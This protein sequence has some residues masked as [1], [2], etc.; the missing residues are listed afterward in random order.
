MDKIARWCFK[1]KYIV[2]GLWIIALV[3]ISV[4]TKQFG[5]KYADSF[6]LPNSGS[7][8]A[9]NLLSKVSTS[10]SGEVDTV[11][12]RVK[13]GTVYDKE[14]K[15]QINSLIHKIS[16]TTQVASV[17]SPY[18]AIGST[19]IS[20]NG[21]IAYSQVN[22]YAQF[23]KLNKQNVLNV[24]ADVKNASNSKV[25][26]E[27]G[28]QAIEQSQQASTSNSEGIG[29][30]AAAIVLLVAFG[31]VYAMSVPLITALMALGVGIGS[32]GLA[33]HFLSIST[34][35][36]IIGALIG[37]GVGIDYAL[38]IITRYRSG[39]I[40]G[41]SPEE[42]AV[43]AIN[44]AGRAVLFAGSTV[45][46]ALLGLLTVG[47][48]F[49]DGVG[50]AAAIVVA[51]TVVAAETLMP[52]LL[53][54]YKMRVIA[55]KVRN[56]I[57]ENGPIKDS[58][59][60]GIWAKNSSFVQKHSILVSVIALLIMLTLAIPFL[61]LRLGSSDAANDA[62]GTTTRKAYDLLSEGF[63]PGFNGPLELVAVVDNQD[64]KIAFVNLAVKIKQLPGVVQVLEFPINP[65]NNLGIIQ[66][67]P[68]TSPE[69]VQT[70]DL[71]KKLNNSIIPQSVQ[72]S[73]LEVYVGGET[74]IFNDFASVIG[75]KLPVFL[76][77]II[78]LSFLILMVAFRSLLIPL[79]A[80]FM[81]VIAVA[82][83]FGVVV[84]I[85]QWGWLSTLLHTGGGGPVESFLP[86]IMVAILFGLS[87]DYQVFLV[88]RMHEEWV[89]TKDNNKAVR[90]GQAETGRVITAAATIMICVFMSF[91]F[92]GQR[93]IAEFGIGLSVAVLLDAFVLRNF[94]VPAL[95]HKFGKANWWI[96]EW[97]DK[98]LPHLAVEPM[99]KKPQK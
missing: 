23:T 39:L 90:L 73:N 89:H 42:S 24:V 56:K 40:A 72:G 61:S 83:A 62:A 74:A 66:V 45:C 79:T 98:I 13:S 97:L 92:E 7:T 10:Q 3:A 35:S 60:T 5:T 86:V 27:I 29:I 94:L 51:V 95:M 58:E 46:V 21:K 65:A 91:I 34:F 26:S 37:L 28:G 17:S 96:P 4:A 82:A 12:W 55:K 81:N 69:S 18:K 78:L 30:V 54:V 70:S 75:S 59:V 44:T 68:S 49:L 63:G 93:V 9:L 87:M 15:A 22:W 19:Q 1:N 2:I 31:S 57:K 85:F 32:I 33:S 67:V 52:A 14:N 8:K 36:P 25:E 11:V 84:A 16:K 64:A 50:I 77:V 47:I 43:K 48:S 41:L 76:A 80:A 99:E 71:I 88:S 20:R 38:F 53:G 6:S